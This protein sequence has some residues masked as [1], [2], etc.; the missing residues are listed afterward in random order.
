MTLSRRDKMLVAV[1]PALVIFIG[2]AIYGLPQWR[3]KLGA[4]EKGIAS[5]RASLPNH[6]EEHRRQDRLSAATR[7]AKAESEAIAMLQKEIATGTKSIVDER[8]DLAD[9]R[10]LVGGTA[11]RDALAKLKM[12]HTEALRD[13]VARDKRQRAEWES[14]HAA[15]LASLWATANGPSTDRTERIERLDKVLARFDLTVVDATDD[16]KNE[17]SPPRLQSVMRAAMETKGLS[18]PKP[19]QIRV[20][21]KYSEIAAALDSLARGD[22]WA[23]PLGLAMKPVADDSGRFEWTLTVWV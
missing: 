11:H 12:E 14:Q 18:P 4:A 22:A 2:Y 20:R 13:L 10:M 21:G 9:A 5:T 17:V 19:R 6:A 23:V 3:A 15:A 1:L 7:E 16:V 8:K